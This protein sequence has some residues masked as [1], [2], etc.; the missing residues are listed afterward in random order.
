MIEIQVAGAGAGK[1]Y[2]LAEKI[3]ECLR[4]ES[5]KK[6]FALTY[7]NSAKEEIEAEL[8]KKLGAIHDRV[9]IETVHT[10]LLNEVIYPFSPFVLN[11]SYST[12]TNSP[13]N[14]RYS[15]SRIKQLK[16]LNIMHVDEVYSAA[17]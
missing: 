8:I 6:I 7:T 15:T 14:P 3:V 12:A 5:H 4:V 16:A 1:T 10:F 13:L 2:S 11:E 9:E 17:R